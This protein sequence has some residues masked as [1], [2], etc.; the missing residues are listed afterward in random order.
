[1]TALPLQSWGSFQIAALPSMVDFLECR[2]TNSLVCWRNGHHYA[3]VSAHLS[4]FPWNIASI[5]SLLFCFPR[6]FQHRVGLHAN[7]PYESRAFPHMFPKTKGNTFSI[8]DKLN[9][10]RNSFTFLANCVVLGLGLAVF[11]LMKNKEQEFKVIAL[12]VLAIG[13]ATSI[14]FLTNIKE[15]ELSNVCNKK[16]EELKEKLGKIK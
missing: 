12:C 7:Q 2:Q 8:K 9:N 1:V 16:K 3:F 11:S 14:F 6:A 15:T 4:P 13:C 10:Y 5:V